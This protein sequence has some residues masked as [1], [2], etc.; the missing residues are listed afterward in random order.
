[1]RSR[2]SATPEPSSARRQRCCARSPPTARVTAAA[3][4][5]ACPTGSVRVGRGGAGATAAR[6]SVRNAGRM[7]CAVEG[8]ACATYVLVDLLRLLLVCCLLGC[9]LLGCHLLVCSLLACSLLASVSLR[10]YCVAQHRHRTGG[11]A[12]P[13]SVATCPAAKTAPRRA[14]SATTA[15]VSL[16][17]RPLASVVAMQAL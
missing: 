10:A 17:A 14:K 2:C 16:H 7:G 5:G 12:S 9:H 13:A 11:W 3:T 6:P 8:S 1:M 4:A 15:C